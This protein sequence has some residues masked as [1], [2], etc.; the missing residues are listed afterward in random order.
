MA[1][2]SMCDE[3]DNISDEDLLNWDF[4]EV[5]NILGTNCGV[6]EEISIICNEVSTK[7]Y[8]I[9]IGTTNFIDW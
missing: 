9:H 2:Y 6:E 4:D 1:E 3:G 7:F 5:I 8:I